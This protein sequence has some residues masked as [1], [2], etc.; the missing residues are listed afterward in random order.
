MGKERELLFRK[1]VNIYEYVDIPEIL[2]WISK[3]SDEDVVSEL[4][5]NG[6]L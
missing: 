3:M 4:T 1:Y 6:W 5:S 2:G